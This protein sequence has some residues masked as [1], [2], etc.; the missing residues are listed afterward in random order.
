MTDATQ[1]AD[2]I[3]AEAA[4]FFGAYSAAFAKYDAAAVA[5]LFDQPLAVLTADRPLSYGDAAA[6]QGYVGE[7]LDVYRSIGL[8]WPV[9]AAVWAWPCGPRLAR[10]EVLWLLRNEGREEI[11]RFST[12]YVLR[13][14]DDGTWKLAVVISYEEPVKL[15]AANPAA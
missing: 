4:A 2:T 6:V 14:A 15:P 12:S 3:G 5:A 1:I 7:L 13:K 9:P 11:M 8:A 10:A